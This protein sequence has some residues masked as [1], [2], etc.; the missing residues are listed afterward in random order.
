MTTGRIPPKRRRPSPAPVTSS[1]I[2]DRLR[3]QIDQVR[4]LP[5]SAGSA[6][7]AGGDVVRL[8]EVLERFWHDT[9]AR[10]PVIQPVPGEPRMCIVTFLWQDGDA[11]Q[12]L[13]FVNRITDETDLDA[14]VMERVPDTDVWHLSYLM[15]ADWRASYSFHPRWPGLPWPWDVND[16]RSIRRGLDRGV[17]DPRN[18][19][20]YR[21]RAGTAVSVVSLPDAPVQAWHTTRAGDVR[22]GSV[23]DQRGPDD[24]TVWVYQPHPEVSVADVPVVVVLD[25]QWWVDEHG[26]TATMD[27]LIHDALI[28]PAALLMVDSGEVDRRWQELDDPAAAADW[29]ATTLLPWAR[30]RFALSADPREVLIVGQSLGGLTAL[31]TVIDFP[32]VFGGAIAQS[33]SM[34]RVDAESMIGDRDLSAVRVH[35][36]VG[37]QEWA[38]LAA[39]RDMSTWL[40][41]AG[42]DVTLNEFNGGHDWACWR[43]G[44]AEG[45]RDLLRPS[46]QLRDPDARALR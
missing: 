16:H 28:R 41:D 22:R 2:I 13:L 26:L 1:P 43:G 30:S 40:G 19:E 39:N 14:S 29:L 5:Q 21:N 4:A 38:L 17:S 46:P 34:W 11:A 23:R 8:D 10:T 24:R 33:S 31:Q 37:T 32:Q 35:M 25:G 6:H 36:Q 42:A 45:L 9:G 3:E 20:T 44:I 12:V 18:L 27:N 7:A 15:S